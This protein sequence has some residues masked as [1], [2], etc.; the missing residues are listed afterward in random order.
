MSIGNSV[1]HKCFIN[2]SSI[3]INPL[4]LYDK[5]HKIE[6]TVKFDGYVKKLSQKIYICFIAREI[7]LKTRIL[8][9]HLQETVLRNGLN[10][11]YCSVSAR[12]KCQF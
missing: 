12:L 10:R 2:S 5:E 7:I 4:G 11:A 8:K 6:E 1:R 3:S 9:P